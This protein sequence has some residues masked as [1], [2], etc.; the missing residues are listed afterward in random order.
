MELQPFHSDIIIEPFRIRSVEPIRFTTMD[1]RRQLL[2]KAGYNPFLLK[3]KDVLIDLLTDSGT[4]AMSSAQWAGMIASDESYA[5]SSSFYKLESAVQ[6]I[7]GFK[8]LIPT[9]QGR[10]AENILFTTIAKDGDVIPSNTHFDTTR[11]HV[12]HAGAEARDLVIDEGRQPRS[13][14]PFKGNMNLDKL[15]QTIQEVGADRIPVIMITVTN[16]S[17]GGQPVSMEN[18]KEVSNIARTHNIPFFIDACRFA[19]NAWFIKSREEGYADKTPLEIAQE[20]FSYAD[21]CTMSAKKDGMANIGGFLALNSDE[22]ASQCRNLEILTEGFPTYGGMAGYDMEAVATGLYEALDEDYLRYR[23]RSIAYLGDKLTEAGVPIV[24]PTGGHAV[25]L[26]AAEIL[27]HISSRQYPAWSFNNTL[28]LLGGVRG[29]E[30]GTVMFGMQPNGTEQPA[31]MELVRLAFPRRMYTQSHVD[32]LAE[33]IIS[34]YE[35]REMLGGYE[36]VSAPQV[37]RHF[38]AKLKPID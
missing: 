5:G 21:G 22:W 34:A 25:Y 8:H 36:I 33:V 18:I 7:T 38:S 15:E 19:E 27:P 20:M 24:Q 23:I 9:H 17:G 3:A 31:A 1:E 14:Y 16:N 10:A 35:Q 32:Y 11:A 2:E 26:D 28:Y 37:L 13:L 29:V 30:I 12:E 6:E 4:G